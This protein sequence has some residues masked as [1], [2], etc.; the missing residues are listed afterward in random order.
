MESTVA[1][2]HMQ[3]WNVAF[4]DGFVVFDDRILN[5]QIIRQLPRCPDR[6]VLGSS[7]CMQLRREYFPGEQFFNHGMRRAVLEDLVA[8]WQ[9]YR[10]RGWQPRQVI[11]GVDAW[12]FDGSYWKEYWQVLRPAFAEI[13][14]EW[15]LPLPTA[16]G[17]GQGSSTGSGVPGINRWKRLLAAGTARAGLFFFRTRRDGLVELVR[18]SDGSVSYHAAFRERPAADVAATIQKSVAFPKH[19]VSPEMVGLLERFLERLRAEGVA[20][21]FV[22]PP[23]HPAFYRLAGKNASGERIEGYDHYLAGLDEVERTIRGI[24][25]KISGKVIG[26]FDPFKV[27]AGDDEFFDWMHP[28]PPVFVRKLLSSES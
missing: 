1:R 17:S 3:G 10:Q 21:S 13:Q 23:Y 9:L 4:R 26:G 28:K 6:V 8:L 2:W 18:R 22:I 11:I 20:V 16:P 19:P 25:G 5:E 14:R 24:A 7:R 27:G 12:S 15:N